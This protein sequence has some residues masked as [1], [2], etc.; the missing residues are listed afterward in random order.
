MTVHVGT[1]GWQYADWRDAFYPREVPQ[2]AW[3]E[4]YASRFA[5]VE[6]NASFYRLP[7]AEVF[8]QWAARTPD[9]VVLCPKASRYLTHVKRLRDPEEPVE[10]FVDRARHLGA[11]RGP[12]LLQLPPTLQADLPLLAAAL[13]RF[14][15]GWRVAV[16]ARHPSWFVDELADLLVA[17][18]AA[19]VHTDRLARPLEPLWR[20]ASW[21][22]LRLH[23]GRATPRPCYGRRALDTW[24]RRIADRYADADVFAF[25][26][27][28][29]RCC[30]VR[31]ARV[32]AAACDRHGLDV[33]RVPAAGDVRLR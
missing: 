21:G 8:A 1:S 29:P 14:P 28:D 11:K 30:A 3:L 13:D 32:F 18:D 7:R 24:A 17:R 23:E 6:V 16:E 33:T 20:T 25:F 26:N 27:N 9:D 2:R 5:V 19:L 22:Y 12:V 10:R 31:D 4:H 15:A